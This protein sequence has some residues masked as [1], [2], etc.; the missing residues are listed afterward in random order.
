MDS[1]DAR[2]TAET[3]EDLLGTGGVGL[4]V[5]LQAKAF[6]DIASLGMLMQHVQTL[7]LSD[8]HLTSFVALAALPGLRA[9]CLN[10]N[11]IQRLDDRLVSVR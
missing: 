1:F 2:M 11:H 6:R 10:N 3:V 9:L 5:V 4:D 8:N 7:D